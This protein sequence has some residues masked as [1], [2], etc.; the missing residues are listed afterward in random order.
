MAQATTSQIFNRLKLS[1]HTNSNCSISRRNEERLQVF[2]QIN[3][4][5]LL[6]WRKQQLKKVLFVSYI[7]ILI[8]I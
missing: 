7:A 5:G 6:D 3:A 8:I 1:S 4:V 2:R